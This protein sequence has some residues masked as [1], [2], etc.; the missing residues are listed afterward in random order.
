MTEEKMIYN[1][2]IEISALLYVIEAALDT[3]TQQTKDTSPYAC[4]AKLIRNTI[5][6]RIMAFPP[7]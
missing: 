2:L 4:F 1:K 5:A 6:T 3:D 7:V